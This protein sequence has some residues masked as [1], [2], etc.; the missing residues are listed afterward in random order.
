M[1]VLHLTGEY[2]PFIW[3]GLGTAVGGLTVAS[4]RAGIEIAVLLVRH[5][6]ASGYGQIVPG[7]T[8]G[9]Y[10]EAGRSRPIRF[11]QSPNEEAIET[12]LR[13]ARQWKP[14][15]VHIHPVELWPIARA[16]HER[17][18]IP[19]V[20]TVHSLNLAEYEIGL[21]HPG[22]LTLW[23]IQQELIA[24][25]S[26]V[27]VLTES[28]RELLL[29]SCPEARS[30]ARIVGNGIDDCE[31]ARAAAAGRDCARPP[32]AL[33]SG[34]FVERKGI[35][36]LLAAIP[37]V[38]DRAP[39]TRFVLVGG[40]GSGEDVARAWLPSALSGYRDRIHFTGWLSPGEVN[41]WYCAAD[42]LVVPSWY[43][44][45]GMVILEGMLYGLP[46]VAAAVGGP[47]EILQ[48]NHTGL[49]FPPKDAAALGD[50]LSC[51]IEDRRLRLRLG[52]AAAET[53]RHRW[54]WARIAD[55]MHAVYREA[56]ADAA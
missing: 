9:E 17:L 42:I 3:G 14:D 54:L 32:L 40:Y 24:A 6:G 2:P 45:F 13:I 50:A 51:L 7:A 28:E 22:I 29:E 30:R 4:A 18:G 47:A 33:Y 26:R 35:R 37:I 21:E 15:A 23:Q 44:P 8:D 46:I 16:L 27:I 11:F 55:R 38:L 20:Y 12:G 56:I 1:R 10:E 19:I 43:E 41:Q 49:L 52:A 31:A 53:V 5:T 39:D 36:E 34:R 48:H 25:A